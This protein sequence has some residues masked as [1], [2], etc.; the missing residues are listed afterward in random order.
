ML[1]SM[2]IQELLDEER[3]LFER[4]P[5]AAAWET[6]QDAEKA[7]ALLRSSQ[8]SVWLPALRESWRQ[9]L[10]NAQAEGRRLPG[11]AYIYAMERTSPGI[12]AAF[13]DSLPAPSMEKLW[14]VD[15]ICQ[16]HDAWWEVLLGKYTI[17]ANIRESMGA[18]FY[19]GLMVCSVDTLRLYASQT[20]RAQKA[21]ENLCEVILEHA[22]RQLGYASLEAGLTGGAFAETIL[23]LVSAVPAA[24]MS[25]VSHS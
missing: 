8:L 22:A 16:A 10:S 2:E 17:L 14:L 23:S 9:D 21:G 3:R 19:G 4:S 11:E 20:E 12:C 1:L 15:W 24:L 6:G 7:L 5:I 25:D 18:H 13:A